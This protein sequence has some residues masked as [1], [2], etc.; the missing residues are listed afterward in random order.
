MLEFETINDAIRARR[1]LEGREIFPGCCSVSVD[2]A[3]ERVYKL[4]V[5]RNDED[6]WDFTC[7]ANN[8][9]NDRGGRDDHGCEFK[10]KSARRREKRRAG[11]YQPA[12]GG[13]GH[14]N[15]ESSHPSARPLFDAPPDLMIPGYY[16]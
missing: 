11:P 7:D 5:H 6:T 3:F 1:H 9:R 13:F 16:V 15:G 4:R 10:S 12:F 8:N 14:F 2:F